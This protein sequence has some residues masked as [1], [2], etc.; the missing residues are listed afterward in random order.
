MFVLILQN[1]YIYLKIVFSNHFDNVSVLINLNEDS[2]VNI[3]C[4]EFIVN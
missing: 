2:D 3:E 4:S 1:D